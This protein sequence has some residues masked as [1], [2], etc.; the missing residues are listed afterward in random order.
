[1]VVNFRGCARIFI[2]IVHLN[3]R[4]VY[5]MVIS[6]AVGIDAVTVRNV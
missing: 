1:M 5:A 4:T 3:A 2:V 6:V